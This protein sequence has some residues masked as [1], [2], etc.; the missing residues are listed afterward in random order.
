MSSVDDDSLSLAG[1]DTPN[2]LQL[3]NSFSSSLTVH[4]HSRCTT[5]TCMRDSRRKNIRG[6]RPLHVVAAEKVRIDIHV[7]SSTPTS[8][9]RHRMPVAA[10]S[11]NLFHPSRKSLPSTF[12][13][14]GTCIPGHPPSP[15]PTH[16]PPSSPD[17]PPSMIHR[18][19]PLM[20]TTQ[21]QAS[22]LRRS[23]N[24]QG[25]STSAPTRTHLGQV[26]SDDI[27]WHTRKAPSRT[28]VG[29]PGQNQEVGPEPPIPPAAARVL[30]PLDA[31]FQAFV[32]FVG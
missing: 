29:I 7:K 19:T 27:L 3:D 5:A 20:V 24:P 16:H 2:F 21:A 25:L 4:C 15:T 13:P 11:S 10:T 28:L 22:G 14:F 18:L 17:N 8:S 6:P 31:T 12:Q 1:L 23:P 26:H 9:P 30:S 32:E